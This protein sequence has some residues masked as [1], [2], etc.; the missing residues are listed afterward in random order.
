MASIGSIR[1]VPEWNVNEEYM[2]KLVNL[3]KIRIVPEWNVNLCAEIVKELT[4]G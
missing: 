3:G 4:S 1:I 2:S